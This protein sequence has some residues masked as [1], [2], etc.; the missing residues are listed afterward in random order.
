MFMV[1]RMKALFHG[2]IAATHLQQRAIQAAE[3]ALYKKQF[4]SPIDVF[5][6]MQWLQPILRTSLSFTCSNKSRLCHHGIC[7]SIACTNW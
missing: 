2:E 3:E 1:F 6:G 4:V 7:A 5:L